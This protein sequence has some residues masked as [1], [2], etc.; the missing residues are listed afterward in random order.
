[1]EQEGESELAGGVAL[2]GLPDRDEVLQRLGHLTPVYVK[3]AG[4]Q[5][6][7]HPVVVLI[8]SLKTRQQGLNAHLS[9]I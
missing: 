4:V 7:P 2:Q 6:V 9:F 8:V 5:E 3:V 1:M